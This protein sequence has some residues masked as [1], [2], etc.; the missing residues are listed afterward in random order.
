MSSKLAASIKA[1]LV[2]KGVSQNHLADSVG[3]SGNTVTSW[4]KDKH[5]PDKESLTELIQFFGLV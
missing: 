3:V 5:F 2:L 1:G 4:V